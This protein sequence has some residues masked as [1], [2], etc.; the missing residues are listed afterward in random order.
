MRRVRRAAAEMML[1][2]PGAVIAER[3]GRLD[4]RERLVQHARIG[5]RGTDA[6][7][8]AQPPA[9]AHDASP[10]TGA[11]RSP[12][13]PE[14]RL[15]PNR[16][17]PYRAVAQALA[18]AQR[19]GGDPDWTGGQRAVSAVTMY[20]RLVSGLYDRRGMWRA[21]EADAARGVQAC[22][23]K[24]RLRRSWAGNWRESSVLLAGR[25]KYV[26]RTTN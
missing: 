26:V 14:V 24:W 10:P 7:E 2:H 1:G 21:Q 12:R 18:A 3:L 8:Q 5:R 15:L 9:R 13:Q 6:R 23:G 4:Q 22:S 25:R 20:L 17:A 11:A 19:E 16:L